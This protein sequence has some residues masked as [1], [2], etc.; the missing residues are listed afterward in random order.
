VILIMGAA[1]VVVDFCTDAAFAKDTMRHM[2]W[3]LFAFV[4]AFLVLAEA[5]AVTGISLGLAS[6]FLPFVESRYVAFVSG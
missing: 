4:T 2:P 5:M 6:V 1:S 3:E